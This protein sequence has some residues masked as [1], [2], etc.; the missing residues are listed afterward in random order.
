MSS[1]LLEA[2]ILDQFKGESTLS[3]TNVYA[4]VDEDTVVLKESVDT[5]AQHDLALHIAQVKDPRFKQFA[6]HSA[7][8]TH[9]S[10]SQ[11]TK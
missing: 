3:D 4:R 8:M 10:P 9:R 6:R 1:K 7:I 5:M 2:R 11:A